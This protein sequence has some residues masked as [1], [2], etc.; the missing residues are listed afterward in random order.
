M[1][2]KILITL[3]AIIVCISAMP[4]ESNAQIRNLKS[5]AVGKAKNINTHETKEEKPQNGLETTNESMDHSDA[6]MAGPE[7]EVYEDK[8][9]LPDY[10]Y[11][12]QRSF[13]DK[14][15]TIKKITDLF[16]K[17]DTNC[18]EVLK[19]WIGELDRPEEWH[20]FTTSAGVPDF[21]RTN[22]Y[23]SVV[24]RSKDGD[25]YYTWNNLALRRDYLG[26]GKF[27]EM[28]VSSVRY[29]TVEVGCDGL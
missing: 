9:E 10:F 26:G 20:T 29:R 2:A 11:E 27:G 6:S 1:K 16:K 18:E 23:F 24:F 15:I 5:R 25:C 28:R 14:S 13:D 12:P 19:I 22:R 3:L 4:F 7:A 21:M 17:Y 8:A